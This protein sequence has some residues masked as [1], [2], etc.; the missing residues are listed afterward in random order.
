M[1]GIPTTLTS[2]PQQLNQAGQNTTASATNNLADALNAGY[3]A[4]GDIRSPLA[5]DLQ[6]AQA[7]ANRYTTGNANTDNHPVLSAT[8]NW[9]SSTT[10]APWHGSYQN[11]NGSTQY[12]SN[13][14]QVTDVGQVGLQLPQIGVQTIQRDPALS[15]QVAGAVSGNAANTGMLNK[16]FAQYLQEAQNVGNAGAAQLASSQA[17]IN[18]AGTI[19]RVNADV[20]NVGTA[21]GN[22]LNNYTTAQNANQGNIA[23]AN[24]AYQ[25]TQQSALAGL[26]ANINTAENNYQTAAQGVAGQGYANA[27]KQTNLYQLGSG[28]P[29]S[30][31]GQLSNRY[32]ADYN[33]IN[34]PLQQQLA[35]MRL[36]DINNLYGIGSNLQSQYLQN[37]QSQFA[38]QGAL[39]ADLANR[40][41]QNNQYT[42]GLDQQTA[43]Y[44]QGLQQQ[45]ATMSP[46]LAAQY[47]QS[48]G[49]PIQM[50]QQIMSGNI[51][52]LNS[53]AGLDQNANLYNLVTPYQNNAPNYLS[54]RVNLP[55]LPG[56]P[57]TGNGGMGG[58]SD[59]MGNQLGSFANYQQQ[60]LQT[61]AGR[62]WQQANSQPAA[63]NYSTGGTAQPQ[64][65]IWNGSQYVMG[66]PNSQGNAN[67]LG[68]NNPY[69]TDATGG[70]SS[71]FVPD[72][73]SF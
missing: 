2:N 45:V 29:T 71:N 11:P 69:A 16:S 5:S 73:S 64:Q 38:G 44:I 32:I 43:Q 72:V 57:T 34:L 23:A 26:G 56:Q 50:A 46:Q 58:L 48:L 54:P 49:I 24:A 22:T 6:S 60:W 63:N 66:N 21:L 27:L 10:G 65:L 39:N 28:T 41:N 40:A 68:V 1:N 18:P 47:L 9:V 33:N 62:A 8:G 4:S 55:G 53:L 61:P 15:G 20:S 51:A 7:S 70:T 3:L 25:K 17:A 36:S 19:S 30:G 52:N 35:G 59:T 67:I 12:F 31:S 14:K 37:L 13:G 42:T